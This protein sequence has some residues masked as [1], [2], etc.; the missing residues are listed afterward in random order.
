MLSRVADSIYWMCRYIERAENVARFIDV[1]LH[2]V[3]DLVMLQH[4]QWVPLVKVTGDEQLFMARYGEATQE[5]VIHFLTFDRDYPN[6]ILSCLSSAR[7]NAR[8][9]REIISSEMWEQVNKF[10]LLVRDASEDGRVLDRPHAFFDEVKRNSH[11]FTGLTWD[12]MSHGEG[13]HFGRLGRLI[14]R[15]DKTSRILDVK[16]FILLPQVEYVGTPYD[17]IQWSAVLKSASGLEMYRK[18]FHRISPR[19]VVQF[20]VFDVEFPRAAAYCLKKA[21]ESLH[22]IGGTPLGTYGNLVERRLGRLSA[23]LHFTDAETVLHSGVHEFL[24]H[25]QLKLNEVG[26]AIFEMFFAMRPVPA[27]WLDE[28]AAQ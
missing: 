28:R 13:W 25:F 1:N 20:L 26:E 9:V 17:N 12:T 27:N 6:S 3:L 4:E 18:R 5:N 11:L 24:D 19:H 2:L 21:Q 7:E 10:Y 14:E 23:D 22:H 15:A 8:S 16:Y